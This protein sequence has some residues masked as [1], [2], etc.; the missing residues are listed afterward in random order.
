MSRF[1]AA[2]GL[3]AACIAAAA[4]GVPA[5]DDL[6]LLQPYLDGV[7]LGDGIEAYRAGTVLLVPLG[8]VCRL[9][10]FGITVNAE[11]T[12]ASGFFIH[13]GRTF[14][15]DLARGTVE[16]EGR[17]ARFPAAVGLPRDLYVDARALGEW[18]PVEVSARLKDSALTFKAREKLP[19]QDQWERDSKFGSAPMARYGGEEGGPKGVPRTVPYAFLD[20]PMADLNLNV[21]R[22]TGQSST[23][24]GSAALGG[25]LLWMSSALLANRDSTGSWVNSRATL[26]REDPSGGILGPLGGRRLE[27]G[28]LFSSNAL[29][30]VGSLPQGR[31]LSLDN[32]PVAFRTRFAARD[33]RGSLPEGWSVEFYQNDSLVGFQRSRPDGLYEFRGVPLRFGV[34]I[35]RLVLHGPRGETQERVERLDIAQS[36]PAPG[37]FLYGLAGVRPTGVAAQTSYLPGEAPLEGAA[38]TGRG[39]SYLAQGSYGLSQALSINGGA[40]GLH[41]KDGAHAFT[42]M[43]LRGVWSFLG[44]QVTGAQDRGPGPR[45]GLAGEAILTTG[46][47]Y[48]TVTLRRDEFRRG[49][50]KSTFGDSGLVSVGRIARD[51]TGL[52][53]NLSGSVRGLPLSLSA[54]TE[55]E[56]YTDG[57]RGS[58]ERVFLS[59][60]AGGLTLTNSLTRVRLPE[61]T[62]PMQGNLTLTSFQRNW[63]WN[64]YL[65]YSPSRVSGWGFQ[66]Q[67]TSADWQFQFGYRAPLGSPGMADYAGPAQATL[68]ATRMTGRIGLGLNVQRTASSFAA[69]VQIQISLGREPRTGKWT[70][71]AQSLASTGAVSAVAFVDANGNGARDPGEA[72]VEGARFKVSGSE[73]PNAIRDPAVTLLSRLSRSQ[74]VDISLDESSLEDPSQ[75]AA[76]RTFAIQPRAGKVARLDFPVTTFG[77]V[78]GTT[79][80]RRGGKRVELGGLEVELLDAAGRRV[81][82]LRSSYDGFFEFPDLAYGEYVLRVTPEEAARMKIKPC[83]RPVRIQAGHNFLDGMDLTIEPLTDSGRNEP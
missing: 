73:S 43:G 39:T 17:K 21:G 54:Q 25:D 42:T 29:D 35:F 1:R 6:V 4:Q 13:P 57:A 56:T 27:M 70:S 80:V 37:T 74:P 45:T 8:E 77:E 10:A 47:R 69:A 31:G 28:D 67:R 58:R 26:F 7:Q 24:A 23:V 12:L 44:L 53:L 11:R 71:D 72:V 60:Q 51:A 41:L 18:F 46:Y 15:L 22:A 33:F 32:Y 5:E 36:Q 14:V 3:A 76:V 38:D 19:V 55:A 75:K 2:L 30:L 48:S 59:T 50:Q 34:N 20:V 81:K 64:G 63:G 65:F 9:L 61:V 79:R 40:A 16:V 52:D 83:Q 66:G 49:F 62:T 68:A 82:A 78:N